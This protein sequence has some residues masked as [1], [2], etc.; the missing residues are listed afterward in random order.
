MHVAPAFFGGNDAR[1]LFDGSGAA[2][3]AD[4]WRGQFR[5]SRIVGD[6]IELV[7]DRAN[8]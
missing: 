6:D 7:M 3:M 8:A 5:S 4:L 2:T 1:P